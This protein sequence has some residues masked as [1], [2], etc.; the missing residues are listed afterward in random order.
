MLQYFPKIKNIINAAHTLKDILK[1]TPL[2][3]DTDLSLKYSANVHLKRE[4]LTPV[5]S[6]K[7][8]G[9]FNKMSSLQNKEGIVTCSAGNHAQGV[10]LSCNKLGINGD[11]FMQKITTNYARIF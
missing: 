1:P 7:L 10:S 6:Y 8:R 5:R 9:A 4:D 2:I 11:I 3:F